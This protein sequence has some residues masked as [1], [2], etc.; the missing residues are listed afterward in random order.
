VIKLKDI[1]KKIARIIL[2]LLLVLIMIETNVKAFGDIRKGKDLFSGSGNSIFSGNGIVIF[3]GQSVQLGFNTIY[4]YILTAAIIIAIII[5]MYIAF[6]IITGS[7]TEKA[8]A[9]AMIYQYVKILI[10]IAL[11]PPAIRLIISL[12]T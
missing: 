9:Q 4:N 11:V 1:T 12:V 5:G 10:G 8:D 6:R 2:I 3:N 7:V